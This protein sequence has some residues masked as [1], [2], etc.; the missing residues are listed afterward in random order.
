MRAA[1][2]LALIAAPALAQVPPAELGSR[3][4]PA[5]WFMREPVIA[6]QGYVRTE[7]P[8]NRARFG[9]RFS[10]VEKTAAEATTAA[11]TK[12]RALDQALAALGIERVRLTTT[13]NTRPLYEQ[14]REKDGTLVDNQRAD[15]IDRYEVTVQ[16]Y[17]TVRDIAVLERV[18]RLAVAARPTA[19]DGVQ[20]NLEP[21]NATK[22]WLQGEAAR[23]ARKRAQLSAEAAGARLG[24]AKVIDPSG[25]VCETQ[26]LAGWPSYVGS[27]QPTDVEVSGSRM[28]APPPP[29]PPPAPPPPPSLQQQ[30]ENVQVTLQPPL[31]QLTASAC[32]IYALLP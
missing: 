8:A 10:A 21:D 2:L 14:Y 19:I 13:L 11:T 4:V 26:V 20:F 28:M 29:P 9:V 30:A 1:L 24:G 17:V 25:G 31:S 22:T 5:P 32:V 7:V 3:Y 12:A 27:N 6:S 16:L 15:K 23:D 18:Y